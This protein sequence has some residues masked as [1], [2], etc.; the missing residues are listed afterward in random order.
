MMAN[1]FIDINILN[2]SDKHSNTRFCCLNRRLLLFSAAFHVA[3]VQYLQ[4]STRVGLILLW[5]ASVVCSQ[6]RASA[7][8][9]GR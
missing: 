2:K 1:L 8:H 4:S 9:V 5:T 3:C 6:Y 7:N